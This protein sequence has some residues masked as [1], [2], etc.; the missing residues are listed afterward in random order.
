[1][2]VAPLTNI[3]T[4]KRYTVNIKTV[5]MYEMVFYLTEIID[6]SLGVKYKIAFRFS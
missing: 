3:P 2:S 5:M 6:I 1:M 4:N